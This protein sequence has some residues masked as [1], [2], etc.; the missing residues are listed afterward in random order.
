M[1][2][3]DIIQRIGSKY[4]IG[5]MENS[6]YSYVKAL[7]SI[8]KNIKDYQK[9]D[10]RKNHQYLDLRFE[11]ERLV[12]L[13]ECKN[14]FGKWKK[15][16]IQKQLQD[17]VRYEKAYSDKKIVAILAET[18]GDDIW[19]WHGQSVIIDEEHRKK[20]EI[21]LRT[22]EEYENIVFGRV[23]DKIKIVDSIKILNET[24]HSDGVD[25]KLRSQF[26]ATCL[27]ALK[28]GLSYKNLKPTLDPDTGSTLTQEKII[29]KDIKSI[30]SGLLSKNKSVDTLNKAGKLSILSNKVLDDQDITSLTYNELQKILEFIDENIIPYINDSNTSGQDLLN[31]FFTAFNKYVGKSDKNQAFT[32]DHICDFMSKA[33]G[34]NKNSRILDP[35][36]GSG[37]FL[38]RAMTD[39]MDDCETEEEREEVKRNQIFGIEYEDGAFGLSSTN[40]LIHGDGNSNVIQASMFERSEW[41]KDKNINIVLM[42][43]PYNA[44]RKFCDPEYVKTWDTRKKQDPS[45]G[46]HFVEWIARHIPANSKIAVLLPMQAAIGNS[47]DIKA[48]KKKMLD[49]YTLEAV[50][51]LPNEMFYPGAAAI[52]CCMIFDLSQKHERSNK[53]TFFGYFKDDKFIKRKG[54]GR[55]EKT[56]SNGNSLWDS[57]KDDWLD[58]YKNKKE[59]PG[60]SVMKKVTWKDEWLAE[61]YMETDYTTLGDKDFQKVLND[62]LSYLVKEGY[63]YEN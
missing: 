28:N 8:G 43:P 31:L 62:Y 27:L 60:L 37:A 49:N 5:N 46:F 34:I 41:I 39:A 12:I 23:N 22:F 57:T 53:E 6:E 61:A 45:K 3:H 4:H 11:N 1:N 15:E 2:R 16:Q 47:S 48:Y 30:L 38:V 10:S 44:T 63:V 42:N 26:V 25:E 52:A 55:I 59:V 17:Y 35:C 9:G 40:M 18:D 54:L 50:F 58:L 56:D 20:E 51:S 29:I 7:A 13:V 32:P 33:V 19:V 24:L 36:S 14:K 21:I